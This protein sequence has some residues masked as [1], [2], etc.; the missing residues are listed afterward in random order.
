MMYV[1]WNEGLSGSGA[2]GF[3]QSVA[4]LRTRDGSGGM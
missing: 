1:G 2:P 4:A 3:C